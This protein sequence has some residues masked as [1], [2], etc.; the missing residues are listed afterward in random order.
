[1][2]KFITDFLLRLFHG[3]LLILTSFKAYFYYKK[4]ILFPLLTGIATGIAFFAIFS[5]TYQWWEG[6]STHQDIAIIIFL[7]LII[8]A[9]ALFRAFMGTSMA[10]AVS[11]YCQ[12]GKAS[13]SKAFFNSVKKLWLII[14]WACIELVVRMASGN[15][16]K[17]S[18]TSF[19]GFIWGTSWQLLTFFIYPLFALEDLGLWGSLKRS[20]ELMKKYGKTTLG[21]VFTLRTFIWLH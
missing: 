17:S 14:R 15:D 10:Y 2:W 1:M 11:D 6:L 3:S 20:T 5:L 9:L 8:F 16:E 18:S 7:L 13:L 19:W 4:L 21:S 12:N